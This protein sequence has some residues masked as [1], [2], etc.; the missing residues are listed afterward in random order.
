MERSINLVAV[1]NKTIG[2]VFACRP[3]GAYKTYY[4][5]QAQ[6]CN[7]KVLT[8]NWLVRWKH[9]H[10]N[11]GLVYVT[12]AYIAPKGESETIKIWIVVIVDLNLNYV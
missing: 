3:F 10:R 11:W 1:L 9:N 8:T 4:R 12:R 2:Q 7:D 5:Y 6:L